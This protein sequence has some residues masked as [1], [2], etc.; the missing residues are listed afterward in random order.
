MVES[1]DQNAFRHTRLSG[2]CHS[3]RHC[4]DRSSA[5]TRKILLS[6]DSALALAPF[7]SLLLDIGSPVAVSIVPSAYDCARLKSAPAPTGSGR[8]MVG[9]LDYRTGTRHFNSMLCR[10]PKAISKNVTA[11]ASAAG[12][13]AVAVTG[14]KATR[15]ADL[16][17]VQ[18]VVLSAC[19]SGQGRPVDG[20]GLLGF[21]TAF[22]AVGAQSLLLSLWN[23]QD[24]ATAVLMQRFYQALFAAPVLLPRSD[25]IRQWPCPLKSPIRG[26]LV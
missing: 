11:R 4:A 3:P 15:A 18:L 12:F 19:T 6:P 23:V 16:S 14:S 10:A 1:R 21:Q 24:R 7:P 20:Q 8:A 25:K 17:G 22:M 5:G 13:Q 2:I 9:W 26:T